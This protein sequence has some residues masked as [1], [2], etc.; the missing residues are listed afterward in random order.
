MIKRELENIIEAKLNKG[1][2]IILVGARQVGKTTLLKSLFGKSDNLLWLNG[3]EP[4]VKKIFENISALRLKTIT[5]N[6][7]SSGFTSIL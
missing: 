6:C 7:I 4:D 3:D 5:S 2:A 1:K